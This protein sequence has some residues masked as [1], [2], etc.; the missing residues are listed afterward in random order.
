[1]M[2]SSKKKKLSIDKSQAKMTSFFSVG[3]KTPTPKPQGGS[4]KRKRVDVGT[5]IKVYWPGDDAWYEGEVRGH[6][7][8][9][10]EVAYDDG[11]V[12]H[13][14]LETERYEVVAMN[15]E[16]RERA[17]RN[18]EE[19]KRRRQEKAVEKTPKRR[20]ILEEEEEDDDAP[21]PWK[22][23]STKKMSFD[24]SDFRTRYM[25]TP[26]TAT[27]TTVSP[28]STSGSSPRI[29]EDED[30]AG[31]DTSQGG[32]GGVL[33]AGAH[34]HDTDPSMRFLTTDR[35]DATG[36][37]PNDPGFDPKTMKV[38]AK[39]LKTLSEVQRQWWT[40]KE[41][42][43]D[44]VLFFKIG[45]FYELYHV[46]ADIGVKE[47]GLVYMKGEQAHAGFPEPAYG[48]YS[49]VLLSKGY[50]VARV[51]QT[52]T[53]DDNKARVKKA[54]DRGLVLDK[55]A[56]SLRREVCSL[57][58]PGTRLYTYLDDLDAVVANDGPLCAVVVDNSGGESKTK[59]KSGRYGVCLL[60][61]PTGSF[62]LAEFDDDVQRSRLR[63]L[64]SER[65][66]VEILLPCPL[67]QVESEANVQLR[68]IVTRCVRRLRPNQ[69]VNIEPSY[70][71][72]DFDQTVAEISES[73]PKASKKSSKLQDTTRWPAVLR[74]AVD[75]R[76]ELAVQ[77]LGS[78]VS[79][80]GRGL[81]DHELLT[82]GN[83]D[84][85]APPDQQVAAAPTEKSAIVVGCDE[86][87]IARGERAVRREEAARKAGG[88]VQDQDD[89]DE[90]SSSSLENASSSS[91]RRMTLD[92]TTL[93]HLEILSSSAPDGKT[94]SLWSFLD[95]AKTPCGSR[96]LK[97]WLARPLF[98]V[99]DI[100]SRSDAVSTLVEAKE[101]AEAIRAKLA[102]IPDLERLLQQLHTLGS[103]RRAPPG[104]DDDEDL[105]MSEKHPDSRAVLFDAIKLNGRK[106]QQLCKALDGLR[107][108][109]KAV[110]LAREHFDNHNEHSGRTTNTGGLLRR[111]LSAFP[112]IEEHLRPFE[113]GFDLKR[114]QKDGTLE[115]APGA[116][117]AYDAAKDDEARVLGRLENWL[118]D[119]KR[120]LR[121]SE[122]SFVMTARDRY[123][124]KL[125]D[126]LVSKSSFKIPSDWTQKSKSKK[127]VSF[128]VPEVVREVERLEAAEKRVQAA[129]VDQL[130][131]LFAA[132][133]SRRSRWA[134][135][136]ESI[137]TLDALLALAHVSRRDGFCRPVVRNGD[138]DHNQ[139]LK[140]TNG[141]HPCLE[142]TCSQVVGNDLQLGG[143]D[144][145]YSPSVLLL[146]GPNM[147]GK[148]TLLRHVCVSAVLAQTGAYVRADEFVF[149][150]VDRIFTRLGASDR[151][152][153]GQ[154]TFMVE[155]LETAS[156][157]K[158]ATPKSLCILDELGRGTAT[159][160]GCAIAHCVVDHLVENVRGCRALF[161]THYH[162]LVQGWAH[163][164]SVQLGHMDCIVE[165]DVE[166]VFLYKLVPGLSPRS[167]GINVARMAHLDDSIIQ[168]AKQKSAE[169]EEAVKKRG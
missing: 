167:F 33:P 126:D 52:E 43:A 46:D 10:H 158:H 4:P 111:C 45:R 91:S 55:A 137:S 80:L 89:D 117:D 14:D 3:N 100:N 56:K 70:D 51:E 18:R 7:E 152:L 54:K 27:T 108:C 92:A 22:K 75:G 2:S 30:M 32:K 21:R 82:M 90:E 19:A 53:P 119:K 98:N 139:V 58:T 57:T 122:A 151:I 49:E 109:E 88:S 131:S 37:K 34:L 161:A 113:S 39:F 83:F 159:F 112:R 35:H 143:D 50:K 64:L 13:V 38:P 144:E 11:D 166:C 87:A 116:D 140:I 9:K 164:P 24:A 145:Q 160:D 106:V 93:K 1:M 94:G 146:T 8:S 69:A 156:V 149:S 41:T 74:Q 134:L 66:P 62:T 104:P 42:H 44:C 72:W 105:S 141:A 128:S 150:P 6:N 99:G 12:E 148:S 28:S 23:Q 129:K 130:R 153:D 147:G 86:A 48:K 165:S 115:A 84:S 102:K 73:L 157:L 114:A 15:E 60:D 125:P 154:S 36:R 5:R 142:E 155:L 31:V 61:A 25:M 107:R 85:Y 96:K 169:F 120:E 123:A 95:C 133:D 101:E 168:I 71:P 67:A 162:N 136:V 97:S 124:L 17:Q 47:A 81:V 110:L 65:Q 78:V 76:A 132:F 163:H 118:E 29:L 63:T 16:Q 127:Y 103:T 121:C 138:D 77:A 68:D 26:N 79:W 59:E 20:V 40:V 135:A